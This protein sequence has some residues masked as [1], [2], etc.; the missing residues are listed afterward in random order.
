MA[1]WPSSLPTV[2]IEGNSFA[3]FLRNG[4]RRN[5]GVGGFRNQPIQGPAFQRPKDV[6]TNDQI[7]IRLSLNTEQLLVFETFYKTELK[8]GT[9]E[10]NLPD[11][12]RRI[13]LVARFNI[14]RRPDIVE[15][16]YDKFLVT[17]TYEHLG[18]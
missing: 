13:T 6:A 4:Y 16:G 17:L 14:S 12:V 11:P 1:D 2:D 10:F 3:F 7:T 9:Q 18:T 8:Q 5:F 15:N